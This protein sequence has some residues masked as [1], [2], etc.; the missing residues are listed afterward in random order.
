[1][2]RRIC[3]MEKGELL[4]HQETLDDDH[5]MSEHDANKRKHLE[6]I[7]GIITRLAQNSFFLKGW[8]VTL[9][10]AVFV[11]QFK[12]PVPLFLLIALL[13]IL[14]FWGLDAY[15]LQQERRYRGLYE[16]VAK[17]SEEAIDFQMDISSYTTAENPRFGYWAALFS[18]TLLAFYVIL[19]AL[20]AGI[21][22]LEQNLV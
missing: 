21:V 12:A 9:V 17:R 20:V 19:T 11:L 14:A 6:L 10:A 1:M 7:Q 15:F 18:R 16:A 22:I 8:T 2:A 3:V 4:A 13:P 5:R